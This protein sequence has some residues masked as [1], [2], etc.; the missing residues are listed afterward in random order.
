MAAAEAG[1][2]LLWQPITLRGVTLKNR[3]MIAPMSMYSAIDGF[4]DDFHLV[5][6]GRFA[7]GGAGLVCMEATAVSPEGRGT[8][9]C[10]GLW[11]DEQADKLQRITSFLHR[12]GCA[13]GIQLFHAG[14]KG[15]S[16]RPWEGGGPLGRDAKD[17]AWD[18]ISVTDAPFDQD[19]A[20]PKAMTEADLD[21]VLDDF[22]SAAQRAAR[23]GFDVLEL[24]CAHGYLLHSFLSPLSNTRDDAYGGNLEGRMRFPLRVV[25]AVRA[26]WPQERPL[27]VRVS[28]VDG[29]DVGWSLE[30]SIAFA[31]ELRRRGVDAVDCSTGGM[32]LGRGQALV[33][34]AP[35]FQVPYAERIRRDA[36]IRTV[37]VGLIRDAA[38]AE[39]ILQEGKADIVAI[40]REA[41]FHPNWAAEAALKL[42]GDGAWK[43]W[44]EQFGWWLLRRARQ[45]GESY[46]KAKAE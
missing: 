40:A 20:R 15:S 29:I 28:S 3:I 43:A 23:A 21:R 31:R 6:L 7:M 42:D 33:S 4:S 13:A 8:A 17:K 1:T 38:H 5:H 32:K 18:I 2:S 12:F 9:G 16:M 35:G 30:E 24:H 44:P 27:F 41:L 14:Q 37:A 11:S 34:R 26:V 36:D 25:D 19:F 10:A 22:V 39:E 45:M 46:S